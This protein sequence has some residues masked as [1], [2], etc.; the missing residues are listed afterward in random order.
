MILYNLSSFSQSLAG[1]LQMNTQFVIE[2]CSYVTREPSL[3]LLINEDVRLGLLRKF[4]DALNRKQVVTSE[5]HRGGYS[6]HTKTFIGVEDSSEEKPNVEVIL[7]RSQLLFEV[8]DGKIVLLGTLVQQEVFYSKIICTVMET[9]K[10]P[11]NH[12]RFNCDV[13]T[14]AL[15]QRL[16]SALIRAVNGHG[17]ERATIFG[18]SMANVFD[19]YNL[20]NGQQ[21]RNELEVS[22]VS[23]AAVSSDQRF[24]LRHACDGFHEPGRH[25]EFEF[26]VGLWHTYLNIYIEEMTDEFVMDLVSA[27]SGNERNEG[28]ILDLHSVVGAQLDD[29]Q[30]GQ[31]QDKTKTLV[32]DQLVPRFRNLQC[33]SL[34]IEHV[35]FFGLNPLNAVFSS[36]EKQ[37]NI[38]YIHVCLSLSSGHNSNGEESKLDTAQIQRIVGGMKYLLKFGVCAPVGR[39]YG[40]TIA[41]TKELFEALTSSLSITLLDLHSMYTVSEE[42]EANREEGRASAEEHNE[43]VNLE[44][45]LMQRNKIYTNWIKSKDGY[46]SSIVANLSPVLLSK[47]TVGYSEAYHEGI[48]VLFDMVR[49]IN[50]DLGIGREVFAI[51]NFSSDP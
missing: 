18:C 40:G 26:E 17:V 22:T 11:F 29:T 37:A 14:E 25:H 44:D 21:D 31:M 50:G 5:T 16:Y 13:W 1:I 28:L 20:V 3:Y 19:F 41:E 47:A 48:D 9:A 43:F 46:R 10:H 8:R 23:V 42:E 4:I 15:Y 7:P 27:S 12:I 39:V 6:F 36:L 49:S 32:L 24:T 35:H 51:Q 30:N 45:Q 33:L 34:R 38:T 2:P